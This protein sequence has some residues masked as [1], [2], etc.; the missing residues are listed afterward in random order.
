MQ[1]KQRPLTLGVLERFSALFQ[2]VEK[3]LR[4]EGRF[5]EKN[6]GHFTGTFP[7]M[8]CAEGLGTDA[9]ARDAVTRVGQAFNDVRERA[10]AIMGRPKAAPLPM[11]QFLAGKDL[12]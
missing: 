3:H 11:R 9:S 2:K 8:R 1:L 4:A 12:W 6:L 7:T 5:H 10:F